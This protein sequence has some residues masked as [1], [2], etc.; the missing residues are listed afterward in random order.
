MANPDHSPAPP[1]DQDDRD[2]GDRLW[3][4]TLLCN[5]LNDR[6]TQVR[7]D[8]DRYQTL[9]QRATDLQEPPPGEDTTGMKTELRAIEQELHQIAQNL[10]SH[11]LPPQIQP[12]IFWQIARF[13]G[14]GMLVGWLLGRWGG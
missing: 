6:L 14:L 13:G 3:E 5:A 2:L 8:Y 7:Q 9:H 11:L 1:E 10:E 4:I 12:E